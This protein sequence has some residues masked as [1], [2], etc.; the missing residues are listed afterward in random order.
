MGTHVSGPSVVTT[1]PYSKQTLTEAIANDAVA[2]A[3]GVLGESCKSKFGTHLP[4]L[5]KVLSIDTALSIQSHPDKVLAQRLHQEFP[6]VYK[7]DNHKPEMAIALTEFEALCGFLPHEGLL[8][9][10]D[11]VPELAQCCGSNLV[12]RY[13]ASD[14]SGR[15][16]ALKNLF[17]ALMTANEDTV[18]EII[19]SMMQ[20]LED[21]QPK[22]SREELI[23][24]LGT[25]Y[26]NDVGILSSCFLNYVK[27]RP[28]QGLELASNEPHA[29][30]SGNIVECMATSDNVIRAGLT[31]KFKDAGV[32]CG[33]LTYK[34]GPPALISGKPVRPS[35]T[36][37]QPQFEEFEVWKIALGAGEKLE[38]LTSEGPTIMLVQA[39]ACDLCFG[40]EGTEKEIKLKKGDIYFVPAGKPI[41]L[42][43]SEDTVVWS[44]AINGLGY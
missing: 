1:G 17:T 39:G 40:V 37:Y 28:G 36:L 12:D 18:T 6:S 34:Q 5:F 31:P 33:S 44:A 8:Q 25:Q 23:L 4:Y 21:K 41:S 13:R 10:L 19:G 27:M 38:G 9:V 11:S 29:Y 3:P 30:L 7:D 2:H 22:T 20:R 24:R 42:V 15:K 16:E 43:S 35:M 14:D 26:P 32:L